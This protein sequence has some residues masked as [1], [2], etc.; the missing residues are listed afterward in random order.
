MP[1]DPFFVLIGLIYALTIGLR[2]RCCGCVERHPSLVDLQLGVRRRLISA[3]IYFTG[4]ITSYFALL[5]VLPIVAGSVVQHR[6]GGLLVAM[7]SARSVRGESSPAVLAGGGAAVARLAGRRQSVVLPP[8]SVAQYVVA[9]NV[10]GFFAVALLSGSL[11]EKV[12]DQPASD[13]KQASTRDRR[14]AGAEP[15]RHRQPA[16]RPGHHRRRDCAS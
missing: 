14:L 4:G 13:L 3:F 2:A 15:A 6:R 8:L 16:E 1:I 7:L 11:A 12:C 9:L 5:Y 10:F